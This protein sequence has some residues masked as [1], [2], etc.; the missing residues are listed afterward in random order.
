MGG[1]KILQRLLYRPGGG[2][3]DVADYAAPQQR[4]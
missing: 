1:G 3:T 2:R 4:T